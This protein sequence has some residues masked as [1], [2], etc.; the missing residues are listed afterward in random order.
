MMRSGIGV[1]LLLQ[2]ALPAGDQANPNYTTDC[3]FECLRSYS[4]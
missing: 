1:G 2:S 4:I 3:K